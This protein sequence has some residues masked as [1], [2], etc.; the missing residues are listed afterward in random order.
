MM[1]AALA[2]ILGVALAILGFHL[3][4]AHPREQRQQPNRLL[5]P[6]RLGRP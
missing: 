5:R 4:Q 3:A 2:T 1:D 6:G